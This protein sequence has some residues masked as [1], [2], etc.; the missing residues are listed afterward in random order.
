[1]IELLA[2][3]VV[4]YAVLYAVGRAALA[5]G[6]DADLGSETQEEWEARQ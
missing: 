1:M 3:M 6:L 4:G 2:T 5:L